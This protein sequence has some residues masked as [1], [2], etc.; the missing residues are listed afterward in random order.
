MEETITGNI[1]H[2]KETPPVVSPMDAAKINPMGGEPNRDP[3]SKPQNPLSK[4]TEELQKKGAEQKA[5]EDSFN[6]M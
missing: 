4:E 2:N 3:F 6:L 1:S 5:E